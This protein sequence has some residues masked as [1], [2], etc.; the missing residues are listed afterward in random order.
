MRPNPSMF[1]I[2]KDWLWV[3][4]YDGLCS[5]EQDCGCFLKD[6]M[7]CGCPHEEDC[8]AGYKCGN[9]IHTEKLESMRKQ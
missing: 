6:L 3:N 4:G 7:P 8:V 1:E 2:I 5:P 9:E